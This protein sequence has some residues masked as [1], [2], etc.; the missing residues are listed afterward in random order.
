MGF[1][2]IQHNIQKKLE[3]TTSKSSVLLTMIKFSRNRMW[4][5]G[6]N[7]VMVLKKQLKN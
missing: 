6:V 4:P 1:V 7:G 5:R 3:V 2:N